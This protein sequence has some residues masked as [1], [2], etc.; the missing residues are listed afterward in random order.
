MKKKLI[1]VLAMLVLIG[2]V[3]AACGN[4]TPSEPTPEPTP[5]EIEDPIEADLPEEDSDL[6][7]E[8]PEPNLGQSGFITV[9]ADELPE[10]FAGF[11]IHLYEGYVFEPWEG[12]DG[13]F[14]VSYGQGS[15]LMDIGQL[16]NIG[17]TVQEYIDN[18]AAN[19]AVI[20]MELIYE[21]PTE[22][23]PFFALPR[24]V[25]NEEGQ[26]VQTFIQDNGQGGIFVIGIFLLPEEWVEGHGPNLLQMLAGFNAP[27]GAAVPQMPQPQ[28]PQEPEEPQEPQAPAE[29]EEAEP[30]SP[31][32]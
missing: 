16:P 24:I 9:S 3:F 1:L 31:S 25:A 5:A 8:E 29:P 11:S 18:M 27:E 28:A 23:F 30:E 17:M 19:W 6:P 4:N 21:P 20:D 22:E 32:V 12:E 15:Y 14:R 2:L 10:G 7:E 13:F 26:E